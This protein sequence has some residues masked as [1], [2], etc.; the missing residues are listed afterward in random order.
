MRGVVYQPINLPPLYHWSPLSARA[1]IVR[2]GLKPT[3]ATSCSM[4]PPGDDHR[5][6]HYDEDD[7]VFT[8]KAVCLGTSPIHAW[9][10]SGDISAE[11]G[12]AWDLWEVRLDDQDRVFPHATIG[13]V[14]DEIRVANVIPKTRVLWVGERLHGRTTTN[15]VSRRHLG[16]SLRDS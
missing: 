14:L 4:M 1:G 9:A 8:F 7:E 13:G 10:L 11:Y 2:R 6:M 16:A 3:C 15:P 5:G 12:E